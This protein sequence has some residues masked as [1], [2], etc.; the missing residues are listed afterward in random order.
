[1][2]MVDHRRRYADANLSA[3]LIF[4][5]SLAE[6]R[7]YTVDDLTPPEELPEME[8]N[9]E[10]LVDSGC[11]ARTRALVGPD[12]G[13]F[14]IVYWGLGNALPGLHLGIFAP[15]RW[16]EDELSSI[17]NVEAHQPRAPLSPRE[18]EVLQLAAEGLSGPTIAE[19]LLMSRGTVKT[20]FEHIYDK[21]GVGDRA[22][23]VA[24]GLRLGFID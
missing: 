22:A 14:E 24:R 21:L 6:L 19:R 1:M 10:R 11:A 20:H 5:L 2:V 9:W 4:R 7:E 13:R 23:A 18:S 8:A 16:P 17:D 3:R 15:A 12:G